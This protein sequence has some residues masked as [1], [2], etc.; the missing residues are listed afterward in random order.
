MNIAVI[1]GG[2]SVEHEISIISAQ[3]AIAQLEDSSHNIIPLYLSK[4]MEFYFGEKLY[5]VKNFS[6]LKQIKKES[7]QVNF[8]RKDSKVYIENIDKKFGNRIISE[9]DV[10]MPIVHGTNVEDGTIAGY[11]NALDLP[12]VFSKHISA[13]MS[14]DKVFQK[15]IMIANNINVVDYRWAYDD[16]INSDIDLVMNRI[17]EMGYP[18]IIKPNTLG[19]SV[20][21]EKAKDRNE[22]E[23]ALTNSV[24]YDTKILIEKMLPS[25]K[26]VN[27][28]VRGSYDNIEVSKT[29]EVG[30]DDEFLSFEDKYQSGG[31]KKTGGSK[32]SQ[33]MASLDRIIPAN[34]DQSIID[35][36]ELNAKKAFRVV[37]NSGL[38]RIDFM[39]D[40]TT[41]ELYLNE[42]NSIPGSLSYYLWEASGVSFRTLLDD[43]IN[44]AIKDYARKSKLQ[45][46]FDSNVLSLQ[47]K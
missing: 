16:E 37:G 46:S 41:N 21:I 45:F 20:G 8:V 11:F 35:Q 34:I 36:I 4:E 3:Q 43:L 15:Q 29:E 13:S 40:T 28:S 23:I 38:I 9:I 14:Q 27:I 17:E 2:N 32:S 12:M 6:D 31:S 26:E 42:I 18:V 5:D 24:K 19:S 7:K 44:Q 30:G 10:V 39:I 25:I 47:S 33:G 22:L 1:F